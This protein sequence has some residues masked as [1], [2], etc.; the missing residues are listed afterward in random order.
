MMS[1][2]GWFNRAALSLSLVRYSPSHPFPRIAAA[3]PAPFS[4]AHSPV[5]S[6]IL[7]PRRR[8]SSPVRVVITHTRPVYRSVR[9]WSGAGRSYPYRVVRSSL[10]SKQDRLQAGGTTSMSSVSSGF[11]SHGGYCDTA[12]RSHPCRGQASRRCRPCH[13]CHPHGFGPHRLVSRPTGT[14]GMGVINRLAAG[15][16]ASGFVSSLLSS[17]LGVSLG[18]LASSRSDGPCVV[19]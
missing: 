13:P 5:R 14:N 12:G 6:L 18:R 10:A 11:S 2:Q 3:Y 15:K 8:H 1:G 9:A 7:L 19:M 17:R 16:Q 4:S